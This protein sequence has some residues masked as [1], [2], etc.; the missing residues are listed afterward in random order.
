MRAKFTAQERS[1][2]DEV[3]EREAF[4]SLSLS[5]VGALTAL[6]SL[7]GCN[8][9]GGGSDSP[10]S[11]PSGDATSFSVTSDGVGSVSSLV[12]SGADYENDPLEI[13][14]IIPEYTE[15]TSLYAT[16]VKSARSERESTR[17]AKP[18]SAEIKD[19]STPT[20]SSNSPIILFFDDVI[21]SGAIADN[22]VVTANGVKIYG[23]IAISSTLLPEGKYRAV[24]TFMPSKPYP[25]NALVVVEFKK[26]LQDKCG[27]EMENDY[28]IKFK[29]G[30]S[31]GKEFVESNWGFEQNN[32]GAEYIGDGKTMTANGTLAPKSGSKFAAISSGYGI[33]SGA[34]AIAHKSSFLKLGPINH[35]FSAVALHY[36]FISAE[37]NEWVNSEFNDGVVITIYG[38]KGAISKSI[39]SINQIGNLGNGYSGGL[40]MPDDGDIF[41]GQLGWTPY[42]ISDI[43]VGYPAY[44]IFTVSDV[45]DDIYSSILA[46][47]D[48]VLSK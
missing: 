21:Y 43:D 24:L 18:L 26:G 10:S 32:D 2:D 33:L 16:S 4:L 36:D 9:S 27:N 22:I 19:A 5:L 46:I 42:S 17:Q 14:Q 34:P 29:A 28:K 30:G 48:I 41:A 40:S 8:S 1:D 35:N 7:S 45:G 3:Y 25:E 12:Q 31:S 13:L 11:P 23:T 6:F 38:P 20:W 37:F 39:T 44:I 15:P 47:D